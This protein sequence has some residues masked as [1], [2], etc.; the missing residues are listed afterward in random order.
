MS[1]GAV[2]C[3]RLKLR[4]MLTD[5]GERQCSLGGI[6]CSPAP[7]GHRR[8]TGA[9]RGRKW[10]S[11]HGAPVRVRGKWAKQGMALG[12]AFLWRLGGAGREEKGTGS[13]LVPRGG[14]RRSGEGGTV[15][16][17]VGWH[18]TLFEF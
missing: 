4:V 9:S 13:G 5:E 6:R 14:R 1:R 18:C 2:G 3:E 16:C 8:W 11:R 12:D 10:G 15:R 17:C 7:H